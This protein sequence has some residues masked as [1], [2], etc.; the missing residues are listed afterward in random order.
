MEA[1]TVNRRYRIEHRLGEGGM[2]EVYLGHDLLLNRAV[3]IKKLHGR[4]SNDG[5][6][7]ARFER[8]A[9]RAG[10][11]THPNIIEIFDVGEEDGRPYIVMEYVAGET[12]K[13]VIQQEGPFEPDDV[14]A[15][16]EQVASAL[17]YA[18]ERGIVH[19]DIKPQNILVDADGLAKVVDFGIAKGIADASLTDVGTAL[20]T[21]HY[22][23]PEQAS[24]LMA[25]PASDVYS[26]GVVAFEMLTRH[27]PFDSDSPVSIAIQH[28]D[29]DPPPPSAFQ[30]TLGA[31]VDAIVQHALAKNPTLR[32]HS[33]G[34]LA[35]AMAEWRSYDPQHPS[36][37]APGTNIGRTNILP[38][39]RAL[40]TVQALSNYAEPAK[41]RP[42]DAIGR[43][44]WFVGAAVLLSLIA[45]VLFGAS[46]SDGRLGSTTTLPTATSIPAGVDGEVTSGTRSD[47]PST[48]SPTG[49]GA[50]SV[51]S[52]TGSDM[53]SATSL[54]TGLG[55]L[56]REGQPVYS[57]QVAE[58]EVAEQD[59]PAGGAASP[60]DTVVL[61]R[62]LGSPIIDL[63]TLELTGRPMPEA[64]AIIQ[65]QGLNAE[66]EDVASDS[67]E[68]GLVVGTKPGDSAL[69]GETVTL[70]VSSGPA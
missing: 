2:A 4:Y 18:H 54:L 26:L 51:P 69:V 1:T 49:D 45:L 9:E 64:Q 30:P 12:L 25:T 28:I 60:G 13:R 33:A 23:S 36:L 50:I 17:D 59:P 8:E 52:A 7:R 66:V 16:L 39:A 19:R 58:G 41:P 20:G 29:D 61:K 34:A 6:L 56:V 14:A 32:Y 70:L 24:G 62:S 38:A 44:T 22:I 46:L 53:D 15:L 31:S 42:R 57:Q 47:D 63:T 55:L 48:R 11:L 40:H 3:A 67:V 65:D 21:A 68:A 27:V 35:A 37:L 5:A 10:S 43:G